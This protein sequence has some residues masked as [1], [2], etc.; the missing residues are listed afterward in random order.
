MDENVSKFVTGDKSMEEFDDF[1]AALKQMNVDR[2]VE[3]QQ[4]AYDRYMAK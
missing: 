4:T 3:L 1:V 2:C